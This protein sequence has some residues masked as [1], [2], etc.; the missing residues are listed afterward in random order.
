MTEAVHWRYP[1]IH[2]MAMLPNVHFEKAF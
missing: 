1:F 2:T